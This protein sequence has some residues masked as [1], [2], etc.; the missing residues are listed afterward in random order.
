MEKKSSLSEIVMRHEKLLTGVVLCLLIALIWSW[1]FNRTSLIAW[2]TPLSYAGDGWFNL[3]V[4][5]A[6]MDGDIFPVLSKCVAHL[7]APF[8]ANWNDW[9]MTEELIYA[10]IGWLGKAVGLFLAANV[11]VMLAHVLAGL[12]FWYVCKELNYRPAFAFAGAVLFAFSN[13]SIARNFEH[14]TLIYYWHV[15]LML[16][17]TWWVYSSRVIQFKSRQ[18]ILAVVIAAVSGTLSPYY[19]WMFLQF[20]G[21]AVLLHL[22]RKQY[23]LIWFPLLLI[24][25]TATGFL[26][27]NADTLIYLLFHGKNHQAVVR[28]LAGL[29]LYA[30][31]I[32]D[33]VFPPAYHPWRWLAKYGQNH[34]Y[35]I[36]MIKGEIGSPYLG[37][38][39]LAGLF[40]LTATGMYY[41]LQDR[42]QLIPVHL[43]QVLWVLLYAL[44]GGLNLLLGTFGFIF[45]RCTNR[46]SIFILAIVL[47]FLVR[48]LSHKCPVKWVIPLAF[49][50]TVGGLWDQLPP[51]VPSAQVQ[52]TA[53]F[54]QSDRNFTR[55]L[56]SQMT[57]DSLAFQ[58]PVAEFPEIPPI[59]QM[60]AYEHFRPYLFTQHLHY[61][62]GT[63][64][65]RNDANWQI[66]LSK[67]AP[68][69]MVAKLEI[70]GFSAII[71][72]RKGY[73][74]KGARLIGELVSANRPVLA[75]NGDLVAI[76]LNPAVA[77]IIPEAPA[78]R[79]NLLPLNVFKQEIRSP[80]S[81]LK[82]K[83]GEDATI[84]VTVKNSGNEPWSNEGIDERKTNR[85]GLGFHWIDSAGKAIKEGRAV[86][87][88]NLM[89]GS[90]ITLDVKTR[91]PSQPGDYKLRF[92]MVQE[93]VA[94]F[95]DKG[96]PP[97]VVNVKVKS[98]EQ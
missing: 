78:P 53:D 8:S 43:W 58:L 92:S 95:F 55:K 42:L 50:I 39:G 88:T 82:L 90:S 20:L 45:F 60:N 59:H 71:I 54:V 44:V 23:R 93:H 25:V 83:V 46:Y 11:M 94:W 97:F 67:S 65:G 34:Y 14:I 35:L 76:R 15:P 47:L 75:D 69:D 73:E 96:A 77:P 79:T 61:S 2:Q 63:D 91:A 64:K 40:W 37:I 70:Y 72:N 26:V 48:Q 86:L 41:F 52:R 85:V 81:L 56:E 1:V 4:A 51:K 80:V 49:V 38:V 6:F 31:K 30:L 3:G 18:W 66:E 16:L 17:V 9:P 87:P 21:F 27:M 84:A 57:P 98:K 36:S 89:P 7:N 10:T 29:E 5:K 19:T 13:Y 32:P 74:D 33:L 68:A 62:Y 12:S 22:A 28:N 24:G